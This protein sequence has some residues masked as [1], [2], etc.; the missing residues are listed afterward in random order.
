MQK[1][2]SVSWNILYLNVM[3]A[4]ATPPVTTLHLPE[5]QRALTLTAHEEERDLP[6]SD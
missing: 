2:L 5:Q 1:L 4:P 6:G 3:H